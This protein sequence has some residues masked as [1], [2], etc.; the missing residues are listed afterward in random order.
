MNCFFS[1]TVVQ[2]WTKFSSVLW[3]FLNKVYL[4]FLKYAIL[5][6][7]NHSLNN[8]HDSQYVIL[9]NNRILCKVISIKLISILPNH[10][11][12]WVNNYLIIFCIAS[13]KFYMKQKIISMHAE[14]Q[15]KVNYVDIFTL[16]NKTGNKK[17]TF[18]LFL[19]SLLW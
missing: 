17:G 16:Y 7:F 13:C 2:S 18:L 1:I 6:G 4:N 10:N 15:T 5:N 14:L 9:I 12:K 8:F 3:R 11:I 19:L